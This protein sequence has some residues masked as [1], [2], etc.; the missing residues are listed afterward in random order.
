MIKI[1]ERDYGWEDICDLE[2]DCSEAV[3]DDLPEAV[4]QAHRDFWNQEGDGGT[5]KVKIEWHPD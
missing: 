5:I 2:R 4:K 3:S 1:F